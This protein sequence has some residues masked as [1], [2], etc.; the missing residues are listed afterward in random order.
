MSKN[1]ST[2][3]K[4]WGSLP[5]SFL[6]GNWKKTKVASSDKRLVSNKSGI[7]MYCISVPKALNTKIKSLNTPVYIGIAKNLR[8][9]FIEHLDT[10]DGIY[11]YRK[12]FGSYMDFY[13]MKIEPYN[14][15]EIKLL[16]EQAMIDCFGKIVKIDSTKDNPIRENKEI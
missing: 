16:Y 1:W 12:C 13:F 14:K 9:R 6:E 4:N 8:K 7:Y 10:K 2:D 3:K 5:K 11:P 15:N